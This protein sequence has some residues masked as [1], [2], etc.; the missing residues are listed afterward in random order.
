M[1]AELSFA[2]PVL[3]LLRGSKTSAVSSAVVALSSLATGGSFTSV[4]VT[5]TVA[6]AHLESGEPLV[7]PLSLTV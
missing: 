1:S 6:V 4:T 2:G 5:F 7:V 3:S